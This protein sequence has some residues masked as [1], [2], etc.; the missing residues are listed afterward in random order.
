ML[1]E[2]DLL[3]TG[4]EPIYV[5]D[6]NNGLD[7]WYVEVVPNPHNNELQYYTDQSKN[8]DTENGHLTIT[9]L[10][11]NYGGKQYT[12]GRMHSK[13]AWKYGR[14]EV[15]AKLP[16]GYGLWPAIWMMPRDSVY[17]GWPQSGEI[18]I[19]EARGQNLNEFASTIHYGICCDNHYW[20]SSGDLPTQCSNDQYHVYTLDWTPTEL[21]YRYDGKAYYSQSLDRVISWM[22]SAPGQPFDQYFYMILNVAVG[23]DYLDNPKPSTTWNYPDAEM[24]VDYVKVY[25]LED[26]STYQCAVKDDANVN[27]VCGN[28]DWACNSQNSA[29]VSAQCTSELTSCCS[30]PNTCDQESLFSMASAVYSSYDVQVNDASSCD[31]SGTAERK[32]VLIDGGVPEAQCLIKDNA[33]ASD[34]CGSMEWACYS[35]NY[36]DVSSECNAG[37]DVLSC[38][39]SYPDSCNYDRLRSAAETVFQSYYNQLP[40]SSS[41]DFGGVC[42]LDNSLTPLE[43]TD[44]YGG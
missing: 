41:C 16:N 13:F 35:Q 18:D 26:I 31:F 22:Y 1:R 11:E 23:G 33:A 34:I 24:L 5:E 3:S 37:S 10:K 7:D 36:A 19:M 43:C 39:G 6:F 42:Y 9:P 14:V 27:D 8:I 30:S 32:Y 28:V 20:E 44:G 40:S 21:V 12:S 25:S 15:R 17:G 38:C 2:F 4:I 29:D